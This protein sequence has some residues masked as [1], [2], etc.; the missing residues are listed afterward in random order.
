MCPPPAYSHDMRAHMTCLC[1][2]DMR[3]H[4]GWIP[5]SKPTVQGDPPQSSAGMQHAAP[6]GEHT[7]TRALSTCPCMRE[8]EHMGARAR[9]HACAHPH[10]RSGVPPGPLRR[11]WP[12]AAAEAWASSS[13]PPVPRSRSLQHRCCCRRLVP[14]PPPPQRLL[15]SLWARGHGAAAQ[16]CRTGRGRGLAGRTAGVWAMRTGLRPGSPGSGGAGRA[17]GAARHAG[18][19]AAGAGGGGG[20][21]WRAGPGRGQWAWRRQ[22]G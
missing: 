18:R 5:C 4:C 15:P 13:R 14:P 1:S 16:G 3:P 9:P 7:R 20:G 10:L 17:G 8:C 22:R 11:P 19:R 2:H 6:E 12:S 21:C